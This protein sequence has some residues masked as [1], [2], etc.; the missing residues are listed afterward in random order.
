MAIRM[1]TGDIAWQ[2]P[3]GITDDLPVDKQRTGR[4]LLAGPIATAGG[5]L[6]I[7]S[8]DDSRFRAIDASSGRELWVTKL[9]R[10]GNADPM[11]YQGRDGK[12][13][14]AIVATDSL[15]VFSLP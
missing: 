7:A 11:T 6:F 5:L 3:L 15:I 4:P 8:T 2:V 13:Y 14:V 9:A 1:A 12:Q 10:R